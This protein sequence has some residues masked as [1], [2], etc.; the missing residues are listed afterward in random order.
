M[1]ATETELLDYEPADHAM[2]LELQIVELVEQQQRAE[3]Q[4]RMDDA[5]ALDAE[6]AALRAELVRTAEAAHTRRG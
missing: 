4:H 5:A 3:V 1:K 2:G 6:I